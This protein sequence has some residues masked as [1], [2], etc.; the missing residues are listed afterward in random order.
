MIVQVVAGGNLQAARDG[1]VA[2]DII[3][4]PAG[5]TFTGTFVLAA[6]R[7]R[8][9]HDSH[10]GIRRPAEGLNGYG[11]GAAPLPGPCGCWGGIANLASSIGTFTLMSVN[12]STCTSFQLA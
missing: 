7:H 10:P 9:H 8:L 1:A 12:F 6:E 5:A 4:R 3:E 11:R 2:G